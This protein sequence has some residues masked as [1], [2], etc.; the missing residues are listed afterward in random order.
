M[1][2]PTSLFP[3]LE[4]EFE[5]RD[6]GYVYIAGIDEAGRGAWAG[7]VVAGAV[8]LPLEREDLAAKLAQVRDSK[9][10]TPR[11]RDELYDVVRETALSWRVGVVSAALIDLIGIVPATRLA[12]RRAVAGLIPSP[13]YLLIDAVKL[14]MLEIAQQSIVR[15]DKLCLSISAASII[16]KV[17][18]DRVMISAAKLFPDYGMERHKGYGTRQHREALSKCGVTSFHRYSYAPIRTL[19]CNAEKES[20]KGA[21]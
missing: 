18:R 15:G 8:I 20:I 10:L 1:S 6:R 9:L 5:L 16:A 3:T 14:P 7:P 2:N 21:C 13:D 4:R 19:L 12:M 11:R 17:Y